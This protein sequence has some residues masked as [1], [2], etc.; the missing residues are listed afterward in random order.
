MDRRTFIEK[1]GAAT[2]AALFGGIVSEENAASP[3]SQVKP[4]IPR[5]DIKIGLYTISYLGIWYKGA[6][7]SWN[8]IIGRC[9]MYGYDSVELDNKRPLGMPMDI[10]RR[11]RDEMRN[12]CEKNGIEIP[13]VAANNDFSSP[14]AE[15][16]EMNLLMVRETARLAA[17][18]GAKMV[19]LF[20]AWYGVPIHEGTGTYDLQRGNYYSFERQYPYTTWLQRYHFVRDCLKEAAD[21]GEEFGVT[22]VLQN[23]APL[24]RHW[25]DMY[26]LIR[27]VD[28]PR[29]KACLD[30]P[31]MTRYDHPWVEE[32]VRTV[33][34]LQIH[35][36]FGGEY[37]RD[38]SG[39]VKQMMIPVRFG[40]PL[41]DYEHFV[42]LLR[43]IGYGG[44]LTYELCHP[45]LNEKHDWEGLDF[46]H[47]QVEMAQ[48]FMR[49]I[50]N[51][52]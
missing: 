38:E 51:A 30:L 5:K 34:D 7:L 22:M 32:A 4:V 35:S 27:D 46:V 8:E 3:E 15:H 21:I 50:I 48:E 16:R 33:G 49:E 23:H 6:A 40:R 1:S 43:E 24:I 44:H 37:Y 2:G 52:T 47:Q 31:I 20:A 18:L 14:I 41:P 45:V 10:D 9:K 42:K 19:R 11:K 25:K 39:K 36:H 29:L 26:D 12:V 28:S 17:D 13:C